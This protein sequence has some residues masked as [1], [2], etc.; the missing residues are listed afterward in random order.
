MQKI[1]VDLPEKNRQNA[2]WLL[3]GCFMVGLIFF[4]LRS[5]GEEHRR[6]LAYGGHPVSTFLFVA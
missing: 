2:K 3:G 1:V 5:D 4:L 6:S